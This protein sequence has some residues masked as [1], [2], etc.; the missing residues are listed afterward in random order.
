M[1]V[2][3]KVHCVGAVA[4]TAA[5]ET[6]CFGCWHVQCIRFYRE[7][8]LGLRRR[9]LSLMVFAGVETPRVFATFGRNP[10]HSGTASNQR[11]QFLELYGEQ[12]E[13]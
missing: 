6:R 13:Q 3:V 4:H 10:R 9:W 12:R 1:G 2:L 8:V 5:I 7:T 11:S